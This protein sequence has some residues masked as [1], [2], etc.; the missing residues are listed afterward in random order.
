MTDMNEA[1]A[2]EDLS[3]NLAEITGRPKNWPR[4]NPIGYI[5]NED[6]VVSFERSG[7]ELLMF[8]MCDQYFGISLSMDEVDKLITWLQEQRRLMGQYRDK[9]NERG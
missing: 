5:D 3:T 7:D 6:R 8:E 9:A 1:L 2:Q 4:D